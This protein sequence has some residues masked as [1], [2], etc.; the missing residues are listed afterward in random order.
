[1]SAD[2]VERLRARGRDAGITVPDSLLGHLAA[3]VQLLTRWN[4]RINLTALSLTPPTDAAI[5]RLLIE[6]LV[7]ARYVGDAPTTWFDLGSGGG[8]PAIP[9]KLVRPAVD[10]VMV[11]SKNRKA[12]FLREA[13]RE[14][15]LANAEVRTDRFEELIGIEANR[16]TAGLVTVRA[17]RADPVLFTTSAALLRSGGELMLFAAETNIG[18]KV[19]EFTLAG[20]HPL[21]PG[22]TGTLVVLRRT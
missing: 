12:A 14:L 21:L 10:L 3:Y 7:A 8:S 20:V 19:G 22:R 1:M 18:S 4:E 17:V 2:F 15:D 5:D 11:E 9:L 6:P 13:V 16:R